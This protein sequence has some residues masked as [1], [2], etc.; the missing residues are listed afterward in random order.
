[1]GVCIDTIEPGAV[2]LGLADQLHLYADTW[3]EMHIDT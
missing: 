1:M 3:A 2:R